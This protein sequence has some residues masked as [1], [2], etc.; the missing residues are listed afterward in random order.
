MHTVLQ[1]EDRRTSKKAKQ[2][3]RQQAHN[4]KSLF[5]R[6]KPGRMS[7]FKCTPT[8]LG[9]FA[10][11]LRERR[12]VSRAIKRLRRRATMEEA[13]GSTNL[14]LL[15][16][17]DGPI[18]ADLKRSEREKSYG[19]DQQIAE[20]CGME[21]E[22]GKWFDSETQ[23]FT[24]ARAQV[25][26][27]GSRRRTCLARLHELYLQAIDAMTSFD[28]H[29]VGADDMLAVVLPG[30][31]R[32]VAIPNLIY[33]IVHRAV[34]NELSR[35]FER[36][37]DAYAHRGGISRWNALAQA[38][39][40]IVKD[41]YVYGASVD[42]RKFFASTQVGLAIEAARAEIP[43]LEADLV[44]LLRGLHAANTIRDVNRRDVR[45]GP[46]ADEHDERLPAMERPRGT[47]LQ[48]TGVAPV[49]S[50]IVAVYLL[51]R[52]FEDRFAGRARLLRYSDDALILAADFAVAAESLSF[53]AQALSSQYTL[54]P[55]KTSKHP[56]PL[57]NVAV[58]FLGKWVSAAGI[59]TPRPR[60]RDLVTS[61]VSTEPNGLAH[62]KACSAL[63]RELVLDP[64]ENMQEASKWLELDA[65]DWFDLFQ[66]LGVGWQPHR[67]ALLNRL[68]NSKRRRSTLTCSRRAMVPT[69]STAS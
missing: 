37:R 50:E 52:A 62:R 28:E 18:D 17:Y 15:L 56:I 11:T 14:H 58:K 39:R 10:N 65:P 12:Q 38:K 55:H 9:G 21:I 4:A 24:R 49:L 46:P 13:L 7:G 6:G 40:L 32:E 53:V 1:Q 69:D 3:P 45:L 8:P 47:L 25:P 61:L 67:R 16:R 34:A 63:R 23:S 19:A 29:G 54:H 2:Q 57:R 31:D 66:E 36:P 30:K 48:G 44:T 43:G 22:W 27:R 20:T 64:T 42:I 41:R 35:R 51:D 60:V 5:D 33:R 26:R 59:E 68:V